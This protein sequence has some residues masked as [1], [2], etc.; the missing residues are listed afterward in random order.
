MNGWRLSASTA[1]ALLLAA[2]V[3]PG[4]SA[5]TGT[6]LVVQ[7]VAALRICGRSP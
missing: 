2:S 6:H 3:A 1:P 4:L 5:Q 7:R